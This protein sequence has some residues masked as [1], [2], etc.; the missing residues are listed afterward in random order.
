MP[1]GVAIAPAAVAGAAGGAE[2]DG[3][4]KEDPTKLERA[5]GEED[6]EVGFFYLNISFKDPPRMG[7]YF[8]RCLD[9]RS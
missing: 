3:M 7:F 1:A 6:E 2:D 4:P 9:K 5:P 8:E